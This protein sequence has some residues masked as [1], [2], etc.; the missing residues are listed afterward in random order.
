MSAIDARSAI[1]A[2]GKAGE[3]LTEDLRREAEIK[4]LTAEVEHQKAI[5][6]AMLDSLHKLGEDY[7]RALEEINRKDAEIERL[8][9]EADMAEG[10]ADALVARAKS[11]AIKEYKERVKQE[12][13]AKGLYLVV[14][15]NVLN[16]V[17]KEME[18]DGD[19]GNGTADD[20]AADMRGVAY[21]DGD[22][23]YNSVDRGRG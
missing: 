3:K 11:E 20:S 4:K 8:R 7:S 18:G 10:Y 17:E 22:V 13:I 6:E 1:D 16:N 9:A 12:L 21:V 2:F 14:V 23:E 15:K 19:E 5:A